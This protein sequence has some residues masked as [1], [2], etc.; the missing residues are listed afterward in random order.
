MRC[1]LFVRMW[2]AAKGGRRDDVLSLSGC[3]FFKYKVGLCRRSVLYVHSFESIDSL[4]SEVA[5]AIYAACAVWA[6]ACKN[7][8]VLYF[9]LLPAQLEERWEHGAG[10][11][12]EQG[13]LPSLE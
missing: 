12:L 4:F 6:T 3:S 13:T 5:R 2:L 10:S 1:G 9:R 7:Q 8:S 11:S